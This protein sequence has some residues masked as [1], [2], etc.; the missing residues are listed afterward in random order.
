MFLRNLSD[1]LKVNEDYT[2]PKGQ[3]VAIQTYYVHRDPKHWGADAEECKPERFMDKNIKRHAYAWI[4]FAAGA[5]NCVGQRFAMMEMKM[6]VA[7]VI[8]RLNFEIADGQPENMELYG[9]MILRPWE[10]TLLKIT[11]RTEF[12]F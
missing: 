11:E 3:S 1:D 9:D 7:S 6:Q 12:N 4:P 2:I 10:N 5:R 8:R